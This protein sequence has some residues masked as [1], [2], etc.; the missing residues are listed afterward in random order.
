[1]LKSD[2]HL[3]PETCRLFP[4][5]NVFSLNM[6][7][8]LTRKSKHSDKASA[9]HLTVQYTYPTSAGTHLSYRPLV[10]ILASAPAPEM[11][12]EPHPLADGRSGPPLNE[13]CSCL[14]PYRSRR[15]IAR[16]VRTT[17]SFTEGAGRYTQTRT[18]AS[19]ISGRHRNVQAG[20]L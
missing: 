11:R 3:G 6:Y 19:D 10:L 13:V 9:F 12:A 5:I 20:G 15:A 4:H 18:R 1:M 14:V 2:L 8:T 17:C 7:P 16:L